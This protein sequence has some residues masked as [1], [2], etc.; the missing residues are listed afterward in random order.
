VAPGN[1]SQPGS[2]HGADQLPLFAE[3][4]LKPAWRSRKDIEAN[5]E[6]QEAV[7]RQP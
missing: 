2:P 7:T 3:K 4:K 1:W 5:L 6:R